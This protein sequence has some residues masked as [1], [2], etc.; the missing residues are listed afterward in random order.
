MKKVTIYVTNGELEALEDALVAWN[1]CKKHNSMINA[2]E[3]ELFKAQQTCMAC[4]Q[5]DRAVRRK[6]V[7]VMSKLFR[8]HDKMS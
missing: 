2:S 7:G 8:A 3:V 1:L 6:A 4:I 5:A